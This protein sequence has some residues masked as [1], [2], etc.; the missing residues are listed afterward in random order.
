[1]PA[2]LATSRILRSPFIS[3]VLPSIVINFLSIPTLLYRAERTR[4]ETRSA[5]DTFRLIDGESLFDFAGNR[6]N[7]T[8]ARAFAATFAQFGVDFVGFK[9]LT[10]VSGAMFVVNMRLV[11]VFEVFYRR[12][13]GTCGGLTETAERHIGYELAEFFE[14]FDIAVFSPAFYYSVEDCKH[15]LGTFSARDAL[16]ARFVLGKVHKEPR[17]LP[18][19]YARP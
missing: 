14:H 5:F 8:M 11:F 13:N 1:M 2:F 19:R 3:T 16:A 6:Q 18:Y 9:F 17:H 12:K 7:G 4:V 15:T 10:S